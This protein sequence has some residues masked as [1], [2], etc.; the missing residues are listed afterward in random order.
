MRSVLQ[1]LLKAS[2]QAR[3]RRLQRA[4]STP[5]RILLSVVILLLAILW[6]GQ[7]VASMLLREPYAPDVFRQWI[8]VP[9]FAWFVWHIVRVAWKRPETAIEWSAQEEALIV[10]GPFTTG[11]QLVYRF[12]VILTS[13][14]PKALLTIFVLWPDLSWTSPA[15]LVLALVGLELFRMLMDIGSC[16]LSDRVYRMYRLSVVGALG[17]I[18]LIHGLATIS[19]K[20]AD[21]TGADQIVELV[22]SQQ[23]S[24]VIASFLQNET[25]AVAVVP[26]SCAADVIAGHGT[27]ASVVGKIVV[28]LM[29]IGAMGALI[30][31]CYSVWL[32]IRIRDERRHWRNRLTQTNDVSMS[33]NRTKLTAIPMCG[34]LIWRQYRRVARYRGS[35]LI[36]MAIPAMLLAPTLVS[37]QDPT[38]AFLLVVC[39][40]LFYTFVLLPEA[41]KFDFRLDSDHLCRLKTLP[42]TPTRIVLGQLATPVMLSVLFQAGICLTAGIYRSVNAQLIVASL[43]VTIP[44]IVLF[45][46]LDNLAFLLYPQRPTQ[47]GF[48]AFLRTILKFTG[49]SLVLALIAGAIV[50]WGPVAALIAQALPIATTVGVVFATGVVMGLSIA[51]VIVIGCVVAA[52]RSLDVSLHAI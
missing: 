10:G 13:T 4:F 22:S 47:E 32:T 21:A 6:T 2:L 25:I 15:G 38:V 50:L 24:R 27:I 1:L 45:V 29:V 35:L 43:G 37:T 7:T 34:P 8:I 14:L 36:S 33:G 40:A 20:T 39:G 41:I 11:E 28:M 5:R 23:P 42:M 18:V 30:S 44:L 48:E 26:F 12:M 19:D 49:K 16:C 52:F 31:R 46:A 3:M 51:A 17:V 9:L